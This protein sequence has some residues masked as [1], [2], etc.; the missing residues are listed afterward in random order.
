MNDLTVQ[1]L[2]AQLQE[3]P[4]DALIVRRTSLGTL[5]QASH[6]GTIKVIPVVE[7]FLHGYRVEGAHWRVP[8]N[9]KD[10]PNED[11]LI[12]VVISL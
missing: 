9:E 6:A 12:A 8:I 10:Q 11:R 4:E 2:I 3:M 5:V 1:K 7:K